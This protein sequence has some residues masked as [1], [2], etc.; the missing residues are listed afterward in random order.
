MS[1]SQL[2]SRKSNTSE[3]CLFGHVSLT[4]ASLRHSILDTRTSFHVSSLKQR[5]IWR[6]GGENTRFGRTVPWAID[7]QHPRQS[8]PG[9]WHNGWNSLRG[10]ATLLSEVE[11]LGWRT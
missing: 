9:Q 6:S 5:A 4:L 3:P 10:Q 7:H 8:C 2:Q 11:E 1:M